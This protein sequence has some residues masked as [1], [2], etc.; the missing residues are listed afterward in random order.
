MQLGGSYEHKL[1]LLCIHTT[2]SLPEFLSV[3]PSVPVRC[4]G[5]DYKRAEERTDLQP[6]TMQPRPAESTMSRTKCMMSIH[7]GIRRGTPQR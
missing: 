1:R 4:V 7:R 2:F 3:H 5:C 6:P